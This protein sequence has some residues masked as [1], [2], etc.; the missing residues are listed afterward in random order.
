MA[1]FEARLAKSRP[2]SS[3][4]EG[5]IARRTAARRWRRVAVSRPRAVAVH[6]AVSRGHVLHRRGAHRVRG[7]SV[8]A[9]SGA[10]T[11]RAGRSA[12]RGRSGCGRRD[13]LRLPS[14]LRRP[15]RFPTSGR[16]VSPEDAIA[17]RGA[18]RGS[19]AGRPLRRR[20]PRRSRAR[21]GS[22][23]QATDGCDPFARPL[24]AANADLAWPRDPHVALWHGCTLLREHRG[25]GHI[26][27]LYAAD[28]DPCEAHVLRLAV[29]RRRPGDHR[30]VPRLGRRR[31]VGGG[32]PPGRAGLAR[33]RSRGDAA[34]ASRRTPRSRPTPIGWPRARSGRSARTGSTSCSASCGRWRRRS[35]RRGRSR[36][37]T[38]SGCRGRATRL[39]PGARRQSRGQVRSCGS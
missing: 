14:R 37:R 2:R 1:L 26:A 17:A 20:R 29:Y 25:D 10:A 21:R 6:R 24:F 28:V 33:R 13:V 27:T 9:A 4:A 12:R 19:R 30:A 38:R 18:R 7:R 39:T 31:L 8:C 36:S 3:A 11:S 34:S 22:R 16:M 15:R 23:C 32:R 35:R 5:D